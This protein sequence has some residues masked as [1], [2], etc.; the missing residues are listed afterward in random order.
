MKMILK[1][2]ES[3][4]EKLGVREWTKENNDEIGNM[5]DLYYKL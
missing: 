2:E 1:K 4:E 3:E 5:I